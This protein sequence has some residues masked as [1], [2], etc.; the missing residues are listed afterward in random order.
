MELL[1]VMENIFGLTG[2][3]IRVTSS[4]E[5]VMDMESGQT[6]KINKSIKE[7]TEWIKNKDMEYMNGLLNKSIKVIFGRTIEM[8]SASCTPMRREV[9]MKKN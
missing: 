8:D 4:M 1:M 9:V 6:K 3:F 2:V 7:A 5:F